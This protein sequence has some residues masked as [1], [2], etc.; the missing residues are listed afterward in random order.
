LRVATSLIAR[1]A[2]FT[3]AIATL[4]LALAAPAT[5]TPPATPTTL[6]AFARR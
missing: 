3:G 4:A 1:S 2:R 6:A 5:T